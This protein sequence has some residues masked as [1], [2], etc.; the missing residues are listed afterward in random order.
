MCG[1]FVTNDSSISEKDFQIV[2]KRLSFR[3]PDFQS[4]LV[5]HSGWSLYHSRLSIIATNPRYS[6]PFFTPSG[7]VLVFNGEILNFSS[8]A[9][10]FSIDNAQSDTEVLATLL[11]KKSFDFNMLEGFFSFVYIDRFGSLKNVVRDKFGVKPL[12]YYEMKDVISISSEASVLSDLYQLDYNKLALEEYKVFR[13]PIFSGSYFDNVKSVTPGSC[14]VTGKYFDSTSKITESY[15]K[16]D[17]LIPVLKE[18]ISNSVKSR[19]ISDV[20]VGLLFSSGIDSNLINTS[21]NEVFQCFTGGFEGD[22]DLEFAKNLSSEEINT[23][24]IDEDDFIERFKNMKDLRKEPIS[25]PNEVVLSI[26]AEKWRDMGGRVLLSGEAADEFFAGY[27]NIYFWAL[28][29]KNFVIEDFLD[30]YAYVSSE[31]V[32]EDIKENLREFFSTLQGLSSFEKV[33]QFFVKKHLPLLFRRLDFSLMYSGIEGREPLA[34]SGIYSLAMSFNP[35]DLFFKSRGKFPLRTIASDY[36]GDEFA[37]REK[38]GF[39]IDV[40]K[41]FNGVSSRDRLD[42]Y[43][44]W[45]KENLKDII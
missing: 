43:S 39:P 4:G 26:L 36:F 8:L 42:N 19:L 16:L 10:R 13:G 23:L 22:Y 14:L 30:R 24:T 17:E 15:K 34:S 3:G 32:S 35:K 28:G 37:F 18:E 7:G 33:R 25:L 9:K 1:F 40:K 31:K 2:D 41:I 6:Q 5:K 21:S 12:V 38:V 11:E 29:N 27:D 44:V 20:P 45:S